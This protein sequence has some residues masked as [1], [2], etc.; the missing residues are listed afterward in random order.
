MSVQELIRD[1]LLYR[2]WDL[3]IRA[4]KKLNESFE[5]TTESVKLYNAAVEPTTWEKPDFTSIHNNE[6]YVAA[7]EIGKPKPKKRGRPK[8]VKVE[9]TEE[10][11]DL[12]DEPAPKSKQSGPAPE[13]NFNAAAVK[14]RTSDSQP[15]RNAFV[16]SG[17]SFAKDTALDK[18]L[19][20]QNEPT[21][22]ER[23]FE[24]VPV[25]CGKCHKKE[26]VPPI[27][28]PI[29]YEEGATSTYYCSKCSK[30]RKQ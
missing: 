13:L 28:A 19:W 7:H 11:E 27:L 23:E 12:D 16:D 14:P 3:I 2:D 26:E 30:G 21:P 17:K 8:K 4:Y 10:D 20:G 15:H 24:L 1:G 9:T 22:R 18:K 6:Q 29:R 5:T 25:E